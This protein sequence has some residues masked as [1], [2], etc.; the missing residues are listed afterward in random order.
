MMKDAPTAQS[1]LSALNEAR[2]IFET[3]VSERE[4]RRTRGTNKAAARIEQRVTFFK[5]VKALIWETEQAAMRIEGESDTL[6]LKRKG[7]VDKLDKETEQ[8]FY[9]K[10]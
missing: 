10:A 3:K 2:S 6:H 1:E 7:M 5:D 8:E 9:K 4:G